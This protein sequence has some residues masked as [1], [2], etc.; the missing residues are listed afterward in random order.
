MIRIAITAAA[1]DAIA[2]TLPLGTVAYDA[3]V[4]ANGEPFIWVERSALDSLELVVR[5]AL[6][7]SEV[8]GL[9]EFHAKVRAAR[10]ARQ[11]ELVMVAPD[12]RPWWRRIA[13]FGITHSG[14]NR[15]PHGSP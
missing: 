4:S 8:R 6:L 13:G 14:V 10:D 1:Y 15:P 5:L 3:K 7:D 2:E 12:R 9:R 11:T